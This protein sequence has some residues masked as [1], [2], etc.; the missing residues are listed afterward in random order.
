MPHALSVLIVQKRV[1]NEN[2]IS[3]FTENL[4]QPSH[5]WH[6]HLQTNPFHENNHTDRDQVGSF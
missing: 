3:H 5:D 1:T 2:I 6:C 4:A